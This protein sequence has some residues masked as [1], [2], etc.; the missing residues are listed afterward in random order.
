MPVNECRT[1][2]QRHRQRVQWWS[3][4][5]LLCS[6]AKQLR[7][8]GRTL[9]SRSNTAATETSA[10]ADEIGARAVLDLDDVEAGQ[11]AV[12]DMAPGSLE[13]DY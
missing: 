1:S 3:A 12:T 9:R 11:E 7:G 5:A 10:E 2:L 6:L 13:G 8:R 4:L